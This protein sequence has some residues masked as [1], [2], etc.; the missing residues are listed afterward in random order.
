MCYNS[1]HH[2][3]RRFRRR[4]GH[5]AQQKGGA[6]VND[7]THNRMSLPFSFDGSREHGVLVIHG[8]TGTPGEV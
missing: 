4:A 8:F 6:F 1:F 7:L 2:R 5:P 3:L